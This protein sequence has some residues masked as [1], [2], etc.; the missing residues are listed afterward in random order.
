[1]E[2]IKKCS[3]K[4]EDFTD[5]LHHDACF[6]VALRPDM[7]GGGGGCCRL[8]SDVAGRS[9]HHRGSEGTDAVV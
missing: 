2:T 8:D 1:M 7:E 3:L 5:D 9:G 6:L 4:Y